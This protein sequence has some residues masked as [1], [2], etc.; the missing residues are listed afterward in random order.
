MPSG[1]T[2][3]L[4][5]I[6]E[7]ALAAITEPDV[8]AALVVSKDGRT[9]VAAGN[10]SHVAE[11]IGLLLDGLARTAH[12]TGADREAVMKLLRERLVRLDMGIGANDSFGPWPLT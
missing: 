10:C 11:L 2:P 9:A 4:G 6:A 3:T 8:Q 7:R 5:P 12:S 1:K